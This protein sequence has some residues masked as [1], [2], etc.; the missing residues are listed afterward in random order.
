MSAFLE[1]KLD[2]GFPFNIFEFNTIGNKDKLHWHNYHEI[3]LCL[4]GQG[5]FIFSNKEYLAGPGDLF[6][7][8]NFESHVA[9]AKPDETTTY[10]FIAFLPDLIASPGNRSFEFEYLT[11]FWYDIKAFCNKIN[12]SAPVAKLIKAAML[13]MKDVWEGGGTGCHHLIAADLKRILAL[14]INHYSTLNNELTSIKVT[15]RMKMQPAI[16]YIHQNFRKNITLEDVAKLVHVSESR[17][18]HAFKEITFIGFKEYVAYLRIN[19]AKKLL[20][21]TDDNIADIAA[22][23]GFGNLYQFYKQYEKHVSMTPAQ[24]RRLYRDNIVGEVITKVGF[25]AEHL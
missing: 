20:L 10:L 6:V 1:Y 15:N 12:Q 2:P 13:E 17:F 14:L 18:R 3:G 21:T 11:P 4:S 5:R 7:V 16:N 25:E 9:I 23:V 22:T 8:A 24:Y 19:E